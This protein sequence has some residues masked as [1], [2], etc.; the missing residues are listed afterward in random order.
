M[1]TSTSITLDA[2][3]K[4][5]AL[6]LLNPWQRDFPMVSRPF[7]YIGQTLHMTE[8]QVITQLHVL[9][10]AGALSRI[11]GV[12]AAHAGG[13]ALLAAMAVP[14]Q[15]LDVVAAAVSSHPGVNH[16]YEREHTYNLW[17]VLTAPSEHDLAQAL[18]SIQLRT[19]LHALALR[20]RKAYRIDLGFDLQ[21]PLATPRGVATPLATV[22]SASKVLNSPKPSTPNAAIAKEDMPL[23]ALVEAGLPLVAQ[24]FAVWAQTLGWAETQVLDRL[25]QWLTQGLLRRFGVIVRHHELGFDANAMTV[26]NVPDDHVDACGAMLASCP[27]VTLAYQRKRAPQWPYNLYCMVHGRDRATVLAHIERLTQHCGLGQMPREI[28]FSRRRFKQI[29]A[30]R[31]RAMD[32]SEGVPC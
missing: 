32:S 5:S 28:L 18:H 15:R 27:E 26:F 9:Q 14:A 23:A 22:L 2:T 20:M 10:N 29:G 24:P 12:F 25:Q 1:N 17:F 3:A 31:F 13:A 4:A 6:R 8:A 7:E 30:R 19:G 21:H 16:N 11:G